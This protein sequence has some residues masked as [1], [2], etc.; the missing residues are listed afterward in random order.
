MYISARTIGLII[1]MA[2][3]FAPMFPWAIGL[4]STP[5]LLFS[6]G[7]Q[8]VSAGILLGTRLDGIILGL[9][10]YLAIAVAP[11]LIMLLLMRFFVQDDE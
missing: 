2:V 3:T 6:G 9:P 1:L 7:L 11:L 4:K 10:L 8:G 5:F